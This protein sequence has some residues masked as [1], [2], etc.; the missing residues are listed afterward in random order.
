MRQLWSM[1]FAALFSL[2]FT[3]VGYSQGTP[4]SPNMPATPPAPAEKIQ[5]KERKSKPEHVVGEVVSVDPKAGTLTLK[6]KDKE[7]NL[8]VESKS[9]KK[10]LEDVKVGDKLGVSYTEDSGKLLVQSMQVEGKGKTKAKAK[11]K[12]KPA[13]K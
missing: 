6:D 5:K 10:H 11:G 1:V 7:I 8:S 3:G 2:A 12:D 9:V 4:G 13:T